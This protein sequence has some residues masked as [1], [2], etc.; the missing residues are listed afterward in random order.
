[1]IDLRQEI[2]FL[3]GRGDWLVPT[4]ILFDKARF[5]T[6]LKKTDDFWRALL[7]NPIE[8]PVRC[9]VSMM[10]Q[11]SLC[12]GK[13]YHAIGQL[14]TLHFNKM[15]ENLGDAG[16]HLALAVILALSAPLQCMIRSIQFLA[17]QIS[18]WGQVLTRTNEPEDPPEYLGV[19]KYCNDKSKTQLKYELLPSSISFSKSSFFS[20]YKNGTEFVEGVTNIAGQ[21]IGNAAIA[22]FSTAYALLRAAEGIVNLLICQPKHAGANFREMTADLSIAIALAIMV[23]IHALANTARV[24]THVGSTLAS[25]ACTTQPSVKKD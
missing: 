15:L 7:M 22:L 16:K 9:L 1:M 2:G 25:S 3:Q 21:P 8:M 17:R 12:I 6:P 4:T 14:L 5:T 24:I 19:A 20:P 13:I 18:T 11:V 23:P 10:E